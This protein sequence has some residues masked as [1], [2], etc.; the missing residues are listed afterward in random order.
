MALSLSYFRN[1]SNF[2]YISQDSEEQGVFQSYTPV[3]NLFR[4][5]KIREDIFNNLIYFTNYKIVGDERPDQVAK[6]IYDDETLDWIILISNNILNVR[7]EWPFPQ[8]L[9]DEY[10][11][12]K[13]GSYE[14]IY[15]VRHYVT[16]EVNDSVGSLVLPKGIIVDQN[17]T[18]EYYDSGLKMQATKTNITD[19]VT[20]YQ[21]ES[22]KEDNKRN[23]Y[24][25]KPSYLSIVLDDVKSIMEYKK[26][27]SQFVTRTLARADNPN[28]YTN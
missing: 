25:L 22:E 6:K 9:F 21:F 20:N 28:Y 2:D 7:D 18:V 8:N 27:S 17:Y 3:K 19:P 23:I 4:R 10:L 26:G 5:M 14:N 15:A 24:L 16:R 12:N 1:L 11:L 13:Y